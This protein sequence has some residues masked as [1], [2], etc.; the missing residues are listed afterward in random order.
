MKRQ[1]RDQLRQKS[2]AELLKD[3]EVLERELLDERLT[4]AQRVPSNVRAAGQQR[5]KLAIL[6]TFVTQ[7]DAK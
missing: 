4:R 1:E 5:K 6:K 7:K 3:I 2:K